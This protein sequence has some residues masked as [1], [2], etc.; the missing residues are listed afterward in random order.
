MVRESGK[1]QWTTRKK[2]NYFFDALVYT[3]LPF[4]PLFFFSL[5]TFLL[6]LFSA[7]LAEKPNLTLVFGFELL[8]LFSLCFALLGIYLRRILDEIRHL[9]YYHV[10]DEIQ[11]K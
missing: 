7:I 1:S 9:P 6:G 8:S 10:I 5:I 11:H 3:R 2:M 4:I